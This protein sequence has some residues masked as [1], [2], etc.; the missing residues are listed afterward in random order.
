MVVPKPSYLD[1]AH[2][3]L[4]SSAPGHYSLQHTLTHYHRKHSDPRSINSNHTLKPTRL[5]NNARLSRV[6]SNRRLLHL[7]PNVPLSTQQTT[8]H[9]PTRTNNRA[10]DPIPPHNPRRRPIRTWGSSPTQPIRHSHL[11][12]HNIS[13]PEHQ[14]SGPLTPSRFPIRHANRRVEITRLQRVTS[15]CVD[16]HLLRSDGRY[17]TRRCAQR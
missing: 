16:E 7:P 12:G 2:A 15:Q 3:S 9:K 5:D 4:L 11:L 6:L 1:R 13:N 10:P 14:N 8:N 17:E